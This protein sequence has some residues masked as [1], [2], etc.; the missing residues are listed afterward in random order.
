ME[1]TP[2][3]LIV[4]D[5]REIS[6]LT[7]SFLGKHGFRT[8]IA[9]DGRAASRILADARIDLVVLDVMLPGEDG[10][11]LCRRLRAESA[12]PIIMVTALGEETDRVIGLEMGADDY[13]AKPFGTRELLARIR[14]VLRRASSSQ[15]AAPAADV[16]LTFDGWRLHVAARQLRSPAGARVAL[17]SGEFELLVAFCRHPRRVLSRDQLLDLTQGRAA[18]AFDRSIDIHVSRLRRK[19]EPDPKLPVIITTVRAGGYFFTPEVI[20]E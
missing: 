11:R 15:G 6:R 13:V 2:H 10:L 20:A 9:A 8:T 3:L 19:I 4:E 17:T 14:A 12:I 1:R 7:A 5:D 18:K 16:R